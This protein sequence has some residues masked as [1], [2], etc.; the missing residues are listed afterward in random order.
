MLSGYSYRLEYMPASK[1]THCDGLSRLPLPCSTVTSPTPAEFVNLLE[2]LDSSPVTSAQVRGWTGRDPV[3]ARVLQ[4]TQQGWPAVAGDLPPEYRPF[5]QRVGELSCQGGCLMWGGRIVIP[6]QG[7]EKVLSMLHAGHQGESRTKAFARSYVWWPH[8]DDDISQMVKRCQHCNATRNQARSAP[9]HPWEYPRGPYDRVHI[10]YC[11][12]IDGHMFLIIVDAYSK[13]VDVYPTKVSTT[14]VTIERLRASFATWGL[15]RVLCSDNASSFTCPAF[16]SFCTSHGIEH[17]T[18][19]P[20]SPKSNGLAER[21]VQTFKNSYRSLQ[22]SVGSRVVQ[23]LYQY[24]STPHSTTGRSPA[25]LFIGRPLRT[26]MDLLRPD[27]ADQVEKRQRSQKQYAD[28]GTRSVS[29]QKGD[30]V[31]VTAVDRLQGTEG[32]NWLPGVALDVCSVKV[33][34]MLSDGRVICRHVDHIRRR[35]TETVPE[36]VSPPGYRERGVCE[37]VVCPSELPV[38]GNARRAQNDA[39]C[40]SELPALEGV[41]RAEPEKRILRPRPTAEPDRF[42][43]V[44]RNTDTVS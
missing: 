36:G 34:V 43:T 3:L 35:E 10:D 38:L 40:P 15:P 19:P 18:S 32:R 12:P 28:R 42:V 44:W 20:L 37:D 27:L 17:L 2:F 16:Q 5:Q 23:F 30:A 1:Q 29:V 9:L 22:G 33:T 39:R 24:R 11:G 13:W 21:Y 25:E 31:W 6:T 14:A 4:Y 41:R 26:H 8:M 7:R